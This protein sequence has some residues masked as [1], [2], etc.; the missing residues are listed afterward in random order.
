M[1]R[2]NGPFPLTPPPPPSFFTVKQEHENRKIHYRTESLNN[3]QY[4]E[5]ASNDVKTSLDADSKHCGSFQHLCEE[6]DFTIFVF[7]FNGKNGGRVGVGSGLKG[8]SPLIRNTTWICN[9]PLGDINYL[10]KS[11]TNGGHR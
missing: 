7:R 1:F 11:Y 6:M 4:F 9:S 8:K 3:T 10:K 2:L 5:S